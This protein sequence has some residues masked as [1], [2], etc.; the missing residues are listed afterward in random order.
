MTFLT[1]SETKEH[2]YTKVT[3][4]ESL[5]SMTARNA[6]NMYEIVPDLAENTYATV[7]NRNFVRQS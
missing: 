4:R 2:K 5:A 3:A 7:S 1:L 6:L